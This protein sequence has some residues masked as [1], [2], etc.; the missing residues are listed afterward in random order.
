MYMVYCLRPDPNTTPKRKISVR[1][2][3][4]K[5]DRIRNIPPYRCRGTNFADVVNFTNSSTEIAII[6][7]ETI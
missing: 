6:E 3:F 5:C 2:F 7:I 1:D 4:S